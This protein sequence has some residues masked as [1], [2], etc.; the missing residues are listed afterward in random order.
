MGD[1]AA[2]STAEAS[3]PRNDSGQFAPTEPAYGREGLERAAGFTPLP[4]EKSDE[5]IEGTR[6]G[7]RAASM[8]MAEV[9]SLNNVA[10]HTTGL[11]QNVSMTVDQATSALQ[12][13]RDADSSQAAL[14]E[15]AALQAEVDK[16]RGELP[17]AKQAA[18]T[19]PASDEEEIERALKIP[20]VKEA[21]DKRVN[22]VETKRAAYESSL[23]EVGKARFAALV[24]DHPEFA[25]LPLNQWANAINAMAQR[26]PARAKQVVAR[27]QALA[28]VEAAVHHADAQ[29]TAREQASFR[30]YST[31]ENAR[32]AE[33]TKNVS[34]REMAAVQSEIPAMLK[35]YGVSDPRQFLEAI[36]GQTQFPRASAER[37]MVDAAKYRLMQRAAKAVPARAAVPTVQRPGIPAPRGSVASN[38]IAELNAKLSQNGSLK[39]AAAL[40]VAQ[41]SKRR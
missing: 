39:T 25:S 38:K 28:Q 35:E 31:K 17:Q 12:D 24:G 8:K 7:I 34:P 15:R 4:D 11:K 10:I 26:E 14:D 19:K 6:E 13:S 32:F 29:K 1:V 40:L 2:S 33:M 18:E 9:R 22:E 16:L 27:I 41:R 30:E 23:K 20:R 21:L 3:A 5:P 37:I 36:S